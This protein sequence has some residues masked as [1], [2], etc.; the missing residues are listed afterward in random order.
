[1]VTCTQG[2]DLG[3][4]NHEAVTDLG[5]WRVGGKTLLVVKYAAFLINVTPP[6]LYKD[7]SCF[8]FA[9]LLVRSH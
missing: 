6:P 8:P 1:M 9:V 4:S 7:L 5:A 2:I 3:A